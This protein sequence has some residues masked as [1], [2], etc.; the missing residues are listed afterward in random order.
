MI[1]FIIIYLLSFKTIDIKLY[2][3]SLL[4]GWYLL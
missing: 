4:W 3:W 2:N 1:I